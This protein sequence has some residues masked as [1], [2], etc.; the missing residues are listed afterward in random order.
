V[1]NFTLVEQ[2]QDTLFEFPVFNSLLKAVHSRLK[3]SRY[4]DE[5]EAYL[6]DFPDHVLDY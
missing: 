6:V 4:L 5:D 2:T 1:Y 3:A